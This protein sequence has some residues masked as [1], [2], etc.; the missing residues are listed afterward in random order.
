M[1]NLTKMHEKT[2][3]KRVRFLKKSLS[4]G[5]LYSTNNNMKITRY[6]D[7]NQEACPITRSSVTDCLK[8]GNSLVSLKPKKQK[9]TI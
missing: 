6:C 7:S 4:Q 9:G 2:L 3:F 5:I 1:N 8:I